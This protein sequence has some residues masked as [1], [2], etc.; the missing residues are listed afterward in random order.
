MLQLKGN[1]IPR[2]LV[3]LERLFNIDNVPLQPN[4]V[5]EEDQ[6]GDLNLGTCADP[7]IL[8]LSKRIPEEYKEKYLKLF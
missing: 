1:V 3:P 2:G 7:R 8:K 6:V 5:T 4:K